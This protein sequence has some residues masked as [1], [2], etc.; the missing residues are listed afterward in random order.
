[1]EPETIHGIKDGQEVPMSDNIEITEVHCHECDGYI[2]FALDKSKNG[3]HVVI[4]PKCGHEHCR[5]IEN[6]KVTGDRWESRNKNDGALP[7]QISGNAV[8]YIQVNQANWSQTGWQV[9]QPNANNDVFLNDSWG[10]TQN[11]A[12]NIQTGTCY[13]I[14]ANASTTAAWTNIGALS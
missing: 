11:N 7:A 14:T 3:Q 4:C 12:T 1:M 5:T 6:G 2:K 9:A 13:Y 10:Q 8:Y